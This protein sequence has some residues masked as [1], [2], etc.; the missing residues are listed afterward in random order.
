MIISSCKLKVTP[1]SLKANMNLETI[2]ISIV[3]I[4]SEMLLW[5]TLRQVMLL[6]HITMS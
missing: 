5:S 1:N 3:L 4:R 2:I 6:N